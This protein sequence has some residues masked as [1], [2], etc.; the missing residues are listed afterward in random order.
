MS[1]PTD[2]R[3]LAFLEGEMPEAERA[4]LL[5]ALEADG[6]LRDRLL[7]AAAGDEAMRAHAATAPVARAAPDRGRVP[8]WWLPTAVAATLL[9][10]VPVSVRL[11][12]GRAEAS[13]SGAPVSPAPSYVLVLQGRWP[14]A[15]S[16]G[17]EERRARAD[18]YWGWTST[19]AREGV[20][21]AAGD[22]AWEPGRRLGPSAVP[23]PLAT[24]VVEQADYV[25]GMLALR[26]G[27]YEEAVAIARDCPHLR[28]GGSVSVRRV[29]MGFVTVAGL[30]DWAE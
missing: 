12:G 3:L 2:D 29:G 30:A 7:A 27:T 10:A 5:D 14:D 4:A 21:L 15:A 24:D 22:L 1:G 17:A 6:A 11:S 20:L 18:E 23:V 26:V 13:A 28:Y 19:L 16:V 9:L 25:V 8:W